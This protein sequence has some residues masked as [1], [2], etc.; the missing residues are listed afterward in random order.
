MPATRTTATEPDLVAFRDG[1]DDLLFDL[2]AHGGSG[3]GPADSAK[4]EAVLIERLIEPQ[5][6]PVLAGTPRGLAGCLEHLLDEV[7]GYLEG[8]SYHWTAL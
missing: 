6:T 8:F 7:R 1:V 4:T 2:A 3:L 5:F